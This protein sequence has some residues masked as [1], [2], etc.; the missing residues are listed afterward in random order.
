MTL[1]PSMIRRRDLLLSTLAWGPL[2]YADEAAAPR[3]AAFE[4][5]TL[6][7]TLKALGLP[8]PIPST[9]V[10]LQAP[11]LVE[12]GSVVQITLGSALPGV[13]R[14]LL[15]VDRNPTWLSAVFEPLGPLEPNVVLRLKMQET[16]RV[17]AVAVLED[18]RVLSA[19]REVKVTLGGCGGAADPEPSRGTEP[20]LIRVQPPASG[21]SV[22]R[23][24]LKHEMESGQRK[25]G[26]GKL[27]PAWHIQQ[28]VVRV[29]DRPVLQAQWGPAVSKNPFLQFGMRGLKSGDR[30]ALAWTDNR[31]AGRS[32]EVAVV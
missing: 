3:R 19:A 20:T 31:G 6:A 11:E 8:A 10:T 23:A 13:R 16:S 30:L 5:K 25:D 27:I 26:S 29:N 9:D 4:A 7:D 1:R 12:D 32:D 18:G 24:L 22:V 2:A 17:V 28:V 15:G 14:L 21:S